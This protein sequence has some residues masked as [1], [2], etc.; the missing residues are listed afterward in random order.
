MT[1]QCLDYYLKYIQITITVWTI[2]GASD[3]PGRYQESLQ[4]LGAIKMQLKILKKTSS[5]IQD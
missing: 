1:F 4:K 5:V 2:A 3:L